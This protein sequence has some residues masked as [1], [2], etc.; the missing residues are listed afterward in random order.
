MAS[1]G[2]FSRLGAMGVK[3]SCTRESMKGTDQEENANARKDYVRWGEC[4]G[5]EY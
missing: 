1:T 3:I 4:L 5:S 2:I